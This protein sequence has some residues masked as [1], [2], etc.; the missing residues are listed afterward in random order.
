VD[1]NGQYCVEITHACIWAVAARRPASGRL[2][3]PLDAKKEHGQYSVEIICTCMHLGGQSPT[4]R[5][6]RPASGRLHTSG[7]IGATC[8]GLQ[9]VGGAHRRCSPRRDMGI[10]QADSNN[11]ARRLS[12]NVYVRN[13]RALQ[14]LRRAPGPLSGFTQS[15]SPCHWHY[16]ESTVLLASLWSGLGRGC[17]SGFPMVWLGSRVRLWHMVDGA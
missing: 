6:S 14:F 16:A 15:P 8:T 9:S 17:G 3:Y 2:Q 11:S 10:C 7:R 5:P 12:K 13:M 4:R 1:Q